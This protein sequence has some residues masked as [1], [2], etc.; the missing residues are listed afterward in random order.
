L[1]SW[2]RHKILSLVEFFLVP[3]F[4]KGRVNFKRATEHAQI[5]HCY[6]W[7][8]HLVEY[9]ASQN[10][11]VNLVATNITPKRK[12]KLCRTKLTKQWHCRQWKKNRQIY[13][14]NT[15]L[16]KKRKNDEERYTRSINEPNTPS[17]NWYE[18]TREVNEKMWSFSH[19]K[20]MM[21][22]Y[23]VKLTRYVI[24][25]SISEYVQPN[26]TVKARLV[27]ELEDKILNGLLKKL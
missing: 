11:L 13:M 22:S 27:A 23:I 4:Q 15:H 20:I 5:S 19:L 2:K 3:K 17:S 16:N 12:S 10:F 21:G 9:V 25:S 1:F 18:W 26:T 14:N 7:K 6:V 24:W 8:Y